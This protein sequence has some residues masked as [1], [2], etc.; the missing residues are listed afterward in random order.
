MT[1]ASSS[2]YP[3]HLP[4][5]AAADSPEFGDEAADVVQ[6]SKPPI[7]LLRPPIPSTQG[8]MEYEEHE[9]RVVGVFDFSCT[10]RTRLVSHSDDC[11]VKVWCTRQERKLA[12]VLDIDM[13]ANI[14]CF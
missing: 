14:C 12:S 10:E 8:V 9:K 4:P 13:K 1:G 3:S 11:K 5:P 6:T 7:S 2:S